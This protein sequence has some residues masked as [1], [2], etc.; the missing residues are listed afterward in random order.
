MPAQSIKV[1][2]PALLDAAAS[3]AATAEKAATP[4]GAVPHAVPGS[5][6]DGAWGTIG[7]GMAAQS[8]QMSAEVSPK[9]PEVQAKTSAGVAQLEAQ[10]AENAARIQAV[11]LSSSED[12]FE[13]DGPEYNPVDPGGAA[14]GPKMDGMGAVPGSLMKAPEG[15]GV[16]PKMQGMGAVPDSLIQATS[17]KTSMGD[18]W[19]DSAVTEAE[20]IAPPGWSQDYHGNWTPPLQIDPGG[21]AAGGSGAGRAPV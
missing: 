11:G 18:G 19:D 14:V 5:T 2:P 1:T 8:A 21:A 13:G 9:G 10:D 12:W 20:Q 6:A 3:V 17:F 4:P 16:G 15:A 7:A